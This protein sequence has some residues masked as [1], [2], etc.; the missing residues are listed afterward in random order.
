MINTGR[1]DDN[2]AAQEQAVG[3]LLGMNSGRKSKSNENQSAAGGR[4]SSVEA[5]LDAFKKGNRDVNNAY[6][7]IKDR[8]SNSTKED[9]KERDEE[10]IGNILLALEQLTDIL[11]KVTY[12]SKAYDILRA[13]TRDINGSPSLYELLAR[14]A[15]IM[16]DFNASIKYNKKA[17]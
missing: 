15:F 16:E 14:Q 9:P 1:P 12:F 6:L 8:E 4:R 3:D 2:A 13:A 7:I 11:N 5:V 17:A 10:N